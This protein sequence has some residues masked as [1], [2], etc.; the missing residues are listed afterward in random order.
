MKFRFFNN[1]GTNLHKNDTSDILLTAN[2][3]K[4]FL[5][6]LSDPMIP[7]KSIYPGGGGRSR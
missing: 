1:G 2:I 5:R 3:A 7:V 4:R 6:F